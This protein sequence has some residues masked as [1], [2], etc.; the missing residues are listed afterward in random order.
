MTGRP[1]TLED[2]ARLAGVSR[3]TASRAVIE[4]DK[5]SEARRQAVTQAMDQLGYV[6]NA[7]ARS[8]VT[9][10]TQSVA[11]VVPEPE[12]TVFGDPF[13]QSAISGVNAVLTDTDYQLVLLMGDPAGQTKRVRAYLRSRLADGIVVISHHGSDGVVESALSAGVP[14]T[15][16]GRPF[17]PSLDVAYVDL[18]NVLGG[19]IATNHLIER[20]AQRIGILTGPLDMVAARDRF[21][22]WRAALADAGLTPG[23][24]WHGHFDRASGYDAGL[25]IAE[26]PDRIDALFV[27]SDLMALGVL[28]AFAE[29]NISVPANVRVVGFDD[30]ALAHYAKPSLTTVTNPGAAMAAG[31]TRLLLQQLNTGETP[32]SVSLNPELIVRDSS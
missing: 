11:V 25:Q 8:L 16:V 3:A 2:V 15:L 14:T 7:A 30:I 5:V 4:P 13:F 28:D 27:A 9:R 1:P 29:R 22:G 19:R 23:G 32:S 18:D 31:A 17:Q 21:D 10:R 24:I 6:P 26:G 20:G 12:S